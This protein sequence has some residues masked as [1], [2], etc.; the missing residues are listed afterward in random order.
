MVDRIDGSGGGNS[1]GW[2]VHGGCSDK[3]QKRGDSRKTY[4]SGV[5]MVSVLETMKDCGLESS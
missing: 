1:G 4:H 2:L 5:T 3:V